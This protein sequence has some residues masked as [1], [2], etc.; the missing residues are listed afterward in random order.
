[1]SDRDRK[2]S[3]CRRGNEIRTSAASMGLHLPWSDDL[4]PL[5]GTVKLGA[6]VAPTR[7]A[8][9]P[10]EG[11]D[12]GSDGMPGE[13][14]FRRYRRYA[15][16]GS[17]LIHFEAV[18]F[19]QE[20]RA[21]DYQLV[22]NPS[23]APAI[24]KLLD[25][26]RNEARRVMGHV[27]L[28]Y[29][30]LQES[31]RYSRAAGTMPRIVAPLPEFDERAKVPADISLLSDAEL[32]KV[33][34][35]FIDAAVLAYEIGFDGV[36]VKACHRYLTSDLLAARSRP[37]RWGGAYENRVRMVL[38]MLDGVR[39]R[40]PDPDFQLI[41]RL[42]LY[43]AIQWPHGWGV[44]EESA[45]VSGLPTPDLTEP[46]RLLEQMKERG[47]VYVSTTCGTPYG[48]AWVNRPFDRRAAGT[49]E[50]P[51]HPLKGVCRGIELTAKA[52]RAVPDMAMSGFGYSWLGECIPNVA[53]G[54][55]RQGGATFVGLGREML[56]YPDMPRDLLRNGGI[57]RSKLCLTCSYCSEVMAS[58]GVVGCFIRDR[59]AYG[60]LF[61]SYKEGKI[62][63]EG[64]SQGPAALERGLGLGPKGGRSVRNEKVCM[65]CGVCAGCGVVSVG[66]GVGGGGA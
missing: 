60:E 36:D 57:D 51:E 32:E 28:C 17:G 18:A 23:T 39:S 66:I 40:V 31:G 65:V 63:R 49:P 61:R 45:P 33:R 16:G 1:M 12:A 11:R 9:L 13:R 14:T 8:V 26:T 37:G 42:N 3:A 24:K 50:A 43:D 53:A 4:S 48:R 7:F 6:K 47:V 20:G 54:V 5:F 30:Q 52:Q 2:D 44:K 56:A 35:Q 19:S 64:D 62:A 25:E 58:G 55:I 10:V 59:E 34:D 15:A 22:L 27:P 46:L 41:S 38:E 21:S 29:V